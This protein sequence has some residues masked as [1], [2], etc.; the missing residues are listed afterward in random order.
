MTLVNIEEI[1]II[2]D[3]IIDGIQLLHIG[4]L[5]DKVFAERL[6]TEQLS[7]I[8]TIGTRYNY[9]VNHAHQ[10]ERLALAMFDK[11]GKKYGMTDHCRLLLRAT[12]ILHDIGKYI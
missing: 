10:V 4:N 7:L 9:D 3:R 6:I 1:I 8:E 5:V 11:I 12:A 2:Q